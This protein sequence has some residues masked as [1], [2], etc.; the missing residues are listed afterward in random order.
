VY[1][2]LLAPTIAIPLTDGFSIA[3]SI[4]RNATTYPNVIAAVE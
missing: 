3:S 2:V 4:A 1:Q